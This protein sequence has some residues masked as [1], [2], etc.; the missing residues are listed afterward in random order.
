MSTPD[1]LDS[2]LASIPHLLKDL[3]NLAQNIFGHLLIDWQILARTPAV[4]RNQ[5]SDSEDSD[6]NSS[7][8]SSGAAATFTI[9]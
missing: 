9:A 8:E 6:G 7:E 5:P 3:I 2:L 1:D 4:S